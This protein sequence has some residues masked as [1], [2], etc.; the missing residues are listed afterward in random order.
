MET[1]NELNVRFILTEAERKYS[2]AT[3]GQLLAS[4]LERAHTMLKDEV[5]RQGRVIG[6]LTLTLRAELRDTA[7]GR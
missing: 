1:S 4:T 6:N 7:A 2:Y 3:E 5:A